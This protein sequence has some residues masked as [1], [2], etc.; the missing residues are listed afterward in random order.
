MT[1]GRGRILLIMFVAVL[2]LSVGETALSK[3]MRQTG[4][5]GGGWA[6]HGLAVLRNRWVWAGCAL[7]VFHLAL[8]MAALSA[9]DLSFVLPLTAVS[10]PLAALLAKYYL[11]EHVHAARWIGTFFIT[12]GVAIVAFGEGS[13]P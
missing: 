3:G 13:E 4:S 8:Y 6:A 2:A 9:A 7:L 12:V 1:I 5:A 11:H 10:Y